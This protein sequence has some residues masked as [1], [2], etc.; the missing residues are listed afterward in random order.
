MNYVLTGGAGNTSKPI[1]EKLLAAGHHVTII[2]RNAAHLA[3]FGISMENGHWPPHL[4]FQL[5]IDML[6]YNG[7]YPGV[8]SPSEKEKYL[9]NSPDPELVLQLKK[10][11][12]A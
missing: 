6:H 5:I 9:E 8:C 2:G 11:I 10:H 12:I 4:H 1:A 7:D 3:E